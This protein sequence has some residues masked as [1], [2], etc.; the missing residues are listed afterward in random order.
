MSTPPAL[1]RLVRG[2]LLEHYRRHHRDLG[3]GH[4]EAFVDTFLEKLFSRDVA[5]EAGRA[6]DNLDIPDL[7]WTTPDADEN[8]RLADVLQKTLCRE[9]RQWLQRSG[10][11]RL[12]VER[13]SLAYARVVAGA[14]DGWT[15]MIAMQNARHGYISSEADDYIS[16][17]ERQ[18]I[19]AE[20]RYSG[21]RRR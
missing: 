8:Y 2:V 14:A 6:V 15:Y 1:T 16:D 21:E 3:V 17:E 5:T 13:K 20:A 19:E 9:I 10:V 12:N 18:A 7:P 4:A 11:W